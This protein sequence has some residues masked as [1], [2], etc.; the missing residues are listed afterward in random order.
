MLGIQQQLKLL[1]Y[2]FLF[3]HLGN[4]V[5]W[6]GTVKAGTPEL[7]DK[8]VML[9]GLISNKGSERLGKCRQVV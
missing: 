2:C 6:A 3:G 4:P 8:L 1:S 9:A 5:E 7:D